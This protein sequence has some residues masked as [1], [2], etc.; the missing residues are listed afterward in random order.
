MFNRQKV[1]PRIII[2]QM[3]SLSIAWGIA[4]G[5]AY[6][7]LIKRAIDLVAAATPWQG[8]DVDSGLISLSA[9]RSTRL[10][11]SFG[12]IVGPVVIA[13]PFAI[14]AILV[15]A[16]LIRARPR[17]ASSA[18]V[19]LIIAAILGIVGGLLLFLAQV[20]TR[21]R[22]T[23]F[24]VALITIVIVALLLRLQRFVRRF[25][26]RSPAFATLFFGVFTVVYLVL[27][28]GVNISS[29]VLSQIDVWLAIISF[30]IVLYA[31]FNLANAARRT[32]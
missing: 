20:A 25:Y 27:A 13:L 21:E 5:V 18:G 2:A 17:L 16:I 29:I 24:I 6:L 11:G 1:D 31:G 10:A 3:A 7:G 22:G 12:G 19:G 4:A 8:A 15:F 26:S 30:A 28:N 9:D 14:I 32:R 23:E